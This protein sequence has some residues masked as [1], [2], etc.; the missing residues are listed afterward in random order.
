MSK[1]WFDCEYYCKC[2]YEQECKYEFVWVRFIEI[3]KFRKPAFLAS[4]A[5]LEFLISCRNNP[6]NN[7]PPSLIT[8]HFKRSH[9]KLVTWHLQLHSINPLG[10]TPQQI[11]DAI[12]SASR[13]IL[14]TGSSVYIYSNFPT[15]FDGRWARLAFLSTGVFMS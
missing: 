3:D 14:A 6:E 1:Y 4:L 12:L 7:F 5:A 13:K 15:I 9:Q 10:K 8:R 11:Y 2:E